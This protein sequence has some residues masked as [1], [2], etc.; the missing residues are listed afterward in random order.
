MITVTVNFKL[1]I[2]FFYSDQNCHVLCVVF[3]RINCVQL[4]S[5]S[6]IVVTNNGNLPRK[7]IDESVL[8]EKS[9]QRIIFT[10][11]SPNIIR[12]GDSKKPV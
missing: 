8:L 1:K 3:S 5:E 10:F 4:W 9:I 2:Y 11:F 6:L 12:R 7:V